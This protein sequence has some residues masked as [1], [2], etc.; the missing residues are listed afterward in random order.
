MTLIVGWRKRV[1]VGREMGNFPK[2]R[3][4]SQEAHKGKEEVMGF[5]LSF[6]F[7]F[8]CPLLAQ[9]QEVGDP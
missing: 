5:S 1:G 3:T 6:L 2:E 9:P 4:F 8:P 7:M